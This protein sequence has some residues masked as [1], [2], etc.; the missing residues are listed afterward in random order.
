VT[1][2]RANGEGSI[3]P[4]RCGFAAYVWITTPSGKRRSARFCRLSSGFLL[5]TPCVCSGPG[6]PTS[7]RRRSALCRHVEELQGNIVGVLGV[8][9][10]AAFILD[11]P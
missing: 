11:D 10:Q 7:I 9:V 2:R 5:V 1:S 6:A 8:Q 3:F 4:C